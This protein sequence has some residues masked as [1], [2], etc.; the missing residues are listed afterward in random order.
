[1]PKGIPSTEPK[2]LTFNKFMA[3]YSGSD[4]VVLA[5]RATHAPRKGRV[6]AATVKNEHVWKTFVM[7]GGQ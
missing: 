6:T 4:P 5:F 3:E 7:A 2:K 1:M